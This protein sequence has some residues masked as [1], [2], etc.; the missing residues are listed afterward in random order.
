MARDTRTSHF[1]SQKGRRGKQ[2]PH[3]LLS[4]GTSKQCDQR[5]PDED[6]VVLKAL[7]KVLNP[8]H[9]PMGRYQNVTYGDEYLQTLL[10][11]FPQLDEKTRREDYRMF[12]FLPHNNRQD[13]LQQ[14]CSRIIKNHAEQFPDF[15]TLENISLVLPLTSEPCERAF[16]VQ[17][18]CDELQAQQ[19][20]LIT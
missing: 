1:K 18:F 20:P 3:V 15:F 7:D 16:S 8:K 2:R 13:N 11:A 17:N 5:F 19:G 14:I 6:M 9:L 12:K 4:S 10:K